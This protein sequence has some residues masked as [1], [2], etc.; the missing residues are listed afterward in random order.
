MGRSGANA[1][2]LLGAQ[3][4][5]E[6]GLRRTAVIPDGCLIWNRANLG[7]LVMI[8]SQ[9]RWE[10]KSRMWKM[11]RSLERSISSMPIMN[12]FTNSPPTDPY[13]ACRG[14]AVD[15]VHR[16]S[17][18]ECPSASELSPAVAAAS[19]RREVGSLGSNG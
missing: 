16:G 13:G 17:E 18:E 9:R 6:G 3:W 5:T 8:K 7:L 14:A 10:L 12:C 11:R 1:P 19:D 15:G 4:N 2:S